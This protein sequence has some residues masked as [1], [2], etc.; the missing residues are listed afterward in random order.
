MINTKIKFQIICDQC[1]KEEVIESDS[2]GEPI[3]ILIK[4]G[5][6]VNTSGVVGNKPIDLCPECSDKILSP[7]PD[8]DPWV[9]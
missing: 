5:W 1:H 3:N 7:E 2:P 8:P 6:I 4:N 9:A